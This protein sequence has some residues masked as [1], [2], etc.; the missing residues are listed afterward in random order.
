[1]IETEDFRGVRDKETKIPARMQIWGEKEPES[2]AIPLSLKGRGNSS[3]KMSKYSMKMTFPE[4]K[5]MFGMPADREW[6]LISNHADKTLLRNFTTF[7]IAR[8]LEMDYAPRGTF[9][10][11]YLNRDYMGVYLLTE[12]IK[13]GPNRLAIPKDGKHYLVEFD[14]FYDHN[15]TIID[16]KTGSP[17][18]IHYPKKCDSSCKAP[19]ASFVEQWEKFMPSPFQY[20]SLITKWI[21]FQAYAAHYWI[22]E[23]TKNVDSNLGTS[24]YFS[25]QKDGLIKMGPAWD[26][27]LSYGEY[28][29]Y[30]SKG[31]YSQWGPWNKHLFKN[32]KF[33]AEIS[34]YWKNHRHIF[35]HFADSLD[36]Y[37]KQIEKA[38]EN[39][40]KR[41]PV[42]GTTFL[43]E[44]NQSYSNHGEAVDSLKSWMKQRIKWIDENI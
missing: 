30:S 18:K 14:K 1:M 6:A 10:E 26:F 34:E 11:V 2:E 23:F 36:S 33:K 9:V 7:N 44:F 5:Q 38:A 32:S 41:W 43:W 16:R 8:Q 39:N 15:D 4:K 13:I 31:W 29:M 12:T 24:V 22:E 17:L 25:W 42:L 37:K 35:L 19:L 28:K 21:D 3:L 20:D 27:D 40:F